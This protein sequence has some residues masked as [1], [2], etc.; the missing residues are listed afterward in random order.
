M[1]IFHDRKGQRR[2][3]PMHPKWFILWAWV[4]VITLVVAL[5]QLFFTLVLSSGWKDP[6]A[7]VQ[8]FSLPPMPGWFFD[9]VFARANDHPDGAHILS[10]FGPALFGLVIWLKTLKRPFT[11]FRDLL[12]DPYQG[13]AAL[14]FVGGLHEIAWTPFYYAAY[15]RYLSW[16]ILIPV[17]RDVSFAFMMAMFVLTF[18]RYPGR[19]V[20][21]SIFR[22]PFL[23]YV[24]FLAAWFALPALFGGPLMPVTTLNNPN[25]GIGPYQE[26]PYFGWWW[27]NAIEV[28]S[29]LM[30]YVPMV[31][32]AWRHKG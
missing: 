8:W 9:L 25:F 29:W 18:W 23:A 4:T 2:E 26:T 20:P 15:A 7:T 1:V 10:W 12:G 19:V 14:V 31:I 17:L 32:L 27:V 11:H 24:V 5:W 6:F 22:K 3:A 13:V 21:L 30:L 28:V 16:S